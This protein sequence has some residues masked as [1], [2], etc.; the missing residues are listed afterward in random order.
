MSLGTRWNISMFHYRYHGAAYRR[1][2]L[3]A[4]VEDDEVNDFENIK[5]FV[6]PDY[7]IEASEL[8]S[9]SD[10]VVG[11]G[12]SFMEGMSHGKFVFF[13]LKGSDI[14]C[15][16]TEISYNKAFYK[17]F[18]PRLSTSD[19][20]DAEKSLNVFFSYLDN[21]ED[22]NIYSDWVIDLFNKNHE[23]KIGASKLVNFYRN[24]TPESNIS[25]YKYNAWFILEKIISNIRGKVKKLLPIN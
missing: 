23:V 25:F 21:K 14:P 16:T 17:N 10:V 5:L 13:P 18:S 12:R 20:I 4:E 11:T 7:C 19:G 22:F 15:F 6:T 3:G 24:I 1:V 2:L 8:I 9:Y